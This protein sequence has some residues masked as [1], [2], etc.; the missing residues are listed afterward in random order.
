MANSGATGASSL[1]ASAIMYAVPASRRK[2]WMSN[3]VPG[4]GSTQAARAGSA[5]KDSALDMTI[6]TVA[7]VLWAS[8]RSLAR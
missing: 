5:M 7:V 4:A 3:P 6:R 8:E 2:A 1:T